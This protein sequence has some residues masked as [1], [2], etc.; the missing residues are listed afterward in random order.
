MSELASKHKRKLD[1]VYGCHVYLAVFAGLL[2][3]EFCFDFLTD[4][5]EIALALWLVLPAAYLFA[6]AAAVTILALTIRFWRHRPLIVLLVGLALLALVAFGPLRDAPCLLFG[7]CLGW[8]IAVLFFAGG[9]FFG[10]RRSLC[11]Q[12]GSEANRRSE[13]GA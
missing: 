7:L 9:W 2:S 1:M 10:A 13:A 3:A 4:E 5:I 11:H 6:L 12:S 8:F